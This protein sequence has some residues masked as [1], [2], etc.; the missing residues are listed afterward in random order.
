MQKK[1]KLIVI[2]LCFASSAFAQSTNGTVVD[3]LGEP[4]VGAIVT[5]E[6]SNVSTTTDI[7]GNYSLEVPDDCKVLQYS[8]IGYTPQDISIDGRRAVN[9]TMTED[10]QL[11]D[12]VVVVGYGVQRKVDLTGRTSP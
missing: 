8:Y 7:N 6:G 10:S 9:V 2:A 3:N 5:V 11:L 1:L 4:I 12:D